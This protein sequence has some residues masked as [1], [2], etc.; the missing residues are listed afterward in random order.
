MKKITTLALVG[1][2]LSTPAIAQTVIGNWLEVSTNNLCV[3]GTYGQPNNQSADPNNFTNLLFKVNKNDSMIA[4]APPNSF[5]NPQD[6]K[7]ITINYPDGQ[8]LNLNLIYLV[9]SN[10]YVIVADKKQIAL[11][12]DE[13]MNYANSLFFKIDYG[14]STY[15]FSND[16]A[17]ASFLSF[18][19]CVDEI[20]NQ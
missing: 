13:S 10:L 20:R 16:G 5:K 9:D 17:H 2:L 15:L 7:T 11:M 12:M 3:L 18:Y 1:S 8:T 4:F 14:G 6:I 19:K